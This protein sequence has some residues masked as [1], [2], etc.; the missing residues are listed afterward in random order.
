MPRH[1]L[2]CSTTPTM[3]RTRKEKVRGGVLTLPEPH[4][5]H[6]SRGRHPN[7]LHRCCGSL[8]TA[9]T[10]HFTTSLS[11]PPPWRAHCPALL[12][13]VRPPWALPWPSNLGGPKARPIAVI[14][15]NTHMS[16]LPIT[17]IASSSSHDLGTSTPCLEPRAC[18]PWIKHGHGGAV[19]PAPDQ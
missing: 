13:I 14:G 19:S 12:A 5:G 8:R 16:T 2:W 7:R 11:S 18:S 9:S 15:R 4:Q 1:H 3:S 10:H 6:Q 17:S